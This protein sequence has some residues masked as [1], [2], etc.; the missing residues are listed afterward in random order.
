[1][2]YVVTDHAAPEP[3]HDYVIEYDEGALGIAGE[4]F[5]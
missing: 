5:S 1:M 3:I 2:G 4:D